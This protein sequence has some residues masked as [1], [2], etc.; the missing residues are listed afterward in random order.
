MNFT[1][2]D[3]VQML[4]KQRGQTPTASKELLHYG[5]IR[6]WLEDQD[7]SFPDAV[8]DKRTAARILHQFM[9]LEAG[10]PDIENIKDAEILQDLYTCRVCANHVAQVYLRQL[11]DA[12]EIENNGKICFI[13]NMLKSVS[14]EEAETII[15]KMS[16]NNHI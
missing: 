10:I 16:Q 13:F 14:K 7:E 4:W 8:L 15:S 12:E 3:F 5:H 2:A 11:M 9:K 1:I 6:G